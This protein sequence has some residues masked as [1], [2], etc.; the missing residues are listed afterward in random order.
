MTEFR[1]SA[2][3]FMAGS[4][5]HYEKKGDVCLVGLALYRH[6]PDARPIVGDLP[7][8]LAFGPAEFAGHDL[9]YSRGNI[10]PARPVLEVD[11]QTPFQYVAQVDCHLVAAGEHDFGH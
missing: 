3:P 4:P 2:R 9:R 8:G 5:G 11:V 1:D 7:L 10:G 6:A